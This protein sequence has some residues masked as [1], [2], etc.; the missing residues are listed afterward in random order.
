VAMYFWDPAKDYTPTRLAPALTTALTI[1]AIG[2]LYLGLFPGRI[3]G[4]A[5]AAADSLPLH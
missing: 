5:R 3:L 2:T 1:A 4:Y